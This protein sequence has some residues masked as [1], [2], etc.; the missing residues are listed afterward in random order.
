MRDGRLKKGMLPEKEEE[1]VKMMPFLLHETPKVPNLVSVRV[2][3]V[4]D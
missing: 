2:T 1:Y 4:I 3:L